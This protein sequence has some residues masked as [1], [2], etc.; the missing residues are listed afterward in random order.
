[1]WIIIFF[2]SVIMYIWSIDQLSCL[3]WYNPLPGNAT[4]SHLQVLHLKG[5]ISNS[6]KLFRSLILF[7]SLKTLY[8]NTDFPGTHCKFSCYL[9]DLSVLLAD[10]CGQVSNILWFIIIFRLEESDQIGNFDLGLFWFWWQKFPQQH[11]R[12]ALS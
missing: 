6:R 12:I 3:I 1:M 8:F 5:T 10:R 2:K 9:S 11:W 7:P 4:V